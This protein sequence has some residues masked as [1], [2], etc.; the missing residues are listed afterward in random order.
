MPKSAKA[1]IYGVIVVGSALFA[2]SFINWPA[3]RTSTWL[4]YLVLTMLASS[5]K[6]RLPGLTRT[7]SLSFL[8][9]LFG[10]DRLS[11]PEVLVAGCAGAL[12]QSLW[13]AKTPP[14]LVQVLFNIANL[15]ISVSLCFLAS[16]F[17]LSSGLAGYRPAA[18]ALTAF[19]YFVVNTVLVSGVLTLLEGK[20]LLE[21]SQDWYVW[22]F[23]YY[24]AGA[25]LVGL[26][27]KSGQAVAGEAWLLLVPVA[28]LIHF[29]IGL[30]K[31][32]PHTAKVNRGEDL[33]PAAR[34]YV[35]GVI[36][37]GIVLAGA[38]GY[39]WSSEDLFRFASLVV[40][41]CIAATFKVRL[42][43]LRG[44]ISVSF[45]LLLVALAVMSFSETVFLSVVAAMVQCVWK[46]KKPPTLTRILFNGAC[47]SLSTASA[48]AIC[49][50]VLANWLSESL[51]AALVIA[52][53]VIYT[54]NSLMVATVLCLVEDK[55]L[56]N[57]WQSCYFW[58]CPYYLV[59]TAAAALMITI[60]REAGWP[61]SL[62]VLPI[63]GLVHY[64]YRLHLSRSESAAWGS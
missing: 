40:L 3:Q 54:I 35:Y 52:T 11:L 18:M 23:P 5:L 33:P 61:S 13:K 57:I 27:P 45:V 8:F 63:L 21:V 49:H 22:S 53:V 6:L 7:Y 58:S 2:A 15:T 42:P 34:R 9:L 4:V 44:T 16:H 62:M 31:S 14:R 30:L 26:I 19:L 32:R 39:F 28:Y 29:F 20:R 41:A 43:G 36:A 12:V 51:T 10:I 50:Y 46:P 24:L 47:I 38:A 59:G 60:S 64:S 37:A 55:P 48:Y 56:R 1:Y 17:L 25:I